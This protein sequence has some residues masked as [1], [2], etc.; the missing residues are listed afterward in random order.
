MSRSFH[1]QFPER[2]KVVSL[3]RQ[4]SWSHILALLPIKDSL[5]REFY[6]TLCVNEGWPV[7]VLRERKN[8]RKGWP[9]RSQT[10]KNPWMGNNK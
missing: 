7:R 10:R 4:L 2:E 8:S 9:W 6:A 3:S 1:Q 5:E